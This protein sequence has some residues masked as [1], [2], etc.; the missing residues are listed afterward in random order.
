M[1]HRHPLHRIR[2]LFQLSAPAIAALLAFLPAADAPAAA[3]DIVAASPLPASRP[4][5][6][7][8]P[9]VY[10]R[11]DLLA[12][13]WSL[14]IHPDGGGLYYYGDGGAPFSAYI[15]KGTFNFQETLARVLAISQPANPQERAS[16]QREGRAATWYRVSLQG[17]DSSANQS[18]DTNDLAFG[19][20]LFAKAIA[21]T[22]LKPGVA[23][24]LQAHPP[25]APLPTTRQAPATQP[26]TSMG[27]PRP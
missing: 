12:D 26:D 6:D 14:R 21:A 5:A 4:T 9:I 19:R 27:Q 3:P 8:A 11:L 23:Q 2:S 25:L 13:P 7:V 17:Q 20:E 1:I 22:P 18:R 24:L 10:L 16:Q 15:P